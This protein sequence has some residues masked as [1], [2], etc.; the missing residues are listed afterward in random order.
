VSEADSY[1]NLFRYNVKKLIETARAAGVEPNQPAPAG[2]PAD[3]R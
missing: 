3:A 1:Q 2:G